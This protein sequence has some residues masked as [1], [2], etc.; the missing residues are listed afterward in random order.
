[1]SCARKAGAESA[2]RATLIR[3]TSNENGV[4][5]SDNTLNPRRWGS[6]AA[7]APGGDDCADGFRSTASTLLNE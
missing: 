7:I 5:M 3:W 2:D 1:L 6:W 4:P